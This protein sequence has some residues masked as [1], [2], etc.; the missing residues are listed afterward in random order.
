[1]SELSLEKQFAHSMFCQ[2]VKD[3]SNLESAK[4]LLEDLHLLYL[5][6]QSL[7][8]QLAR[9]DTFRDFLDQ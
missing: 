9:Q 7:F 2:Q 6:Q 1:M 4:K 3:I 8:I 5:G